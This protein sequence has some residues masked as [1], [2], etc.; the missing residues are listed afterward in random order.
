MKLSELTNEALV[1]GISGEL[2]LSER[3]KA[4]YEK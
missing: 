1:R 4:L 2:C 3:R